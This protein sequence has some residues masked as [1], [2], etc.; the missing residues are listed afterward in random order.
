MHWGVKGDF[1]LVFGGSNFLDTDL[2]TGWDGVFRTFTAMVLEFGVLG[3][4]CGV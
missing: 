3:N 2:V 4:G 1:C